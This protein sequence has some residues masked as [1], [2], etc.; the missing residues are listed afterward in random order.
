MTIP[1]PRSTDQVMEQILAELPDGFASTH[2]PDDYLGARFRPVADAIATIEASSLAM[3]QEI[4]PRQA[5]HLLP[6]W[7]RMLGPDPCQVAA[8]ITDTATLGRL[9]YQK[10]TGAGTICAGYFVRLAAEI[11][12]TITITEYPPA[13]LG[14]MQ[15]GASMLVQPPEHCAFTVNLAATEITHWVCGATQC[16]ES[17]GAFRPSV[18]E[19]VIRAQAPAWATPY[20]RYTG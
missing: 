11:G 9:A 4:D 3:L 18:M 19:C 7:T 1:Q 10:L 2:S 5:P 13:A 17:L 6:D 12:E 8:G 16:G 20:F 15:C 14:Q